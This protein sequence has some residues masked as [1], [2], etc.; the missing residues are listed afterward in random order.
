MTI[1]EAIHAR[2]SV[3]KYLSQPLTQELVDQLQSKIAECNTLG[4]LHIQ[5]V[6]Q[7]PRGFYG[8]NS[9]GLLS[10]VENYL[11]MAG[12]KAET[13]SA[14]HPCQPL[15]ERVGYYGQQLVLLAQQLGLATCWAGGSYKKIPNTFQL[16]EGE[17]VVCMIALG[18]P[19]DAGKITRK[20]SL[21]QLSNI[22]AQSPEWFRQGMELVRL[23]PSA[24]NQQKFRLEF[25]PPN[26]VVAHKGFS[27]A[28]FTQIDLG[29]AKLHFEIGAGKDNFEWS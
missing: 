25:L 15:E 16:E 14:S 21:E 26:K 3:R 20:K 28:G 11:V 27:L 10:G 2:H 12:P 18:Y 22:S 17:K 23:A 8:I 9:Y 5:L 19:A 4:R 29:I 6:L 1:Q 7:E 24:I 13:A